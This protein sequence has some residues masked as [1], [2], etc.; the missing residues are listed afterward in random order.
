[1]TLLQS[2]LTISDYYC[3]NRFKLMLIKLSSSK[4]YK[5]VNMISGVNQNPFYLRKSLEYARRNR[6]RGL[7]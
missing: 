5:N 4:E 6:D 2:S 1:M 3:L 7:I